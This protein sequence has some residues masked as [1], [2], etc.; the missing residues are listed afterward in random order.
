MS[1][2]FTITKD[3]FR[4]ESIAILKRTENISKYRKNMVVLRDLE[5]IIDL[6]KPKTILLY[7]PLGFEV[8]IRKLI[9]KYR[10]KLLIVVPFMEG[11]SFK[12]VKYRLPL[13]V[14]KFNI[15]EPPNSNYK[16]FKLD[17]AVVPVVGVDGKFQRVGFGKGMY[18]RFFANLKEIPPIIFIQK[19]F[20]FINGHISGSRKDKLNLKTPL[21]AGNQTFP[22]MYN[23]FWCYI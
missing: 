6:L 21:E 15:Y 20:C 4:K 14:K 11:K 22:P 19:E 10:K 1:K 5:K 8:D 16:L 18:D 7:L 3:T 17:L 13:S 12:M 23:L 2:K 9:L